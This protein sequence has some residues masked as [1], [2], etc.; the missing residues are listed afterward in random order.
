MRLFLRNGIWW[1][2]FSD[3]DGKRCRRTTRCRDEVAAHA[4]MASM[5]TQADRI[6]AGL[7][8]PPLP[9]MK[10][11]D[12]V[13]SWDNALA[14]NGRD[15]AYRKRARR[16][17]ERLGLEA[18]FGVVSAANAAAIDRWLLDIRASRMPSTAN[19]ARAACLSFLGHCVRHGWIDSVPIRTRAFENKAPKRRRALL[20]DEL[21]R[22]LGCEDIPPGRRRV[23]GILAY[24]GLRAG[25]LARLTWSNVDGNTI[26]IPASIAKSGRDEVLPLSDRATRILAS[27]SGGVLLVS[28]GAV[29][30]RCFQRDLQRAGIQ[31]VDARGRVAVLHSLRH[32]FRSM[33]ARAGASDAQARALMRHADPSVTG[34][35]QDDAL[36]DLRQVVDRLSA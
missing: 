3:H 21:E 8:P 28:G 22:L 5:V 31:A 16:Y 9:A 14:A 11:A 17:V 34:G 29:R 32:T 12:A 2:D 10:Y 23:Y 1:A 27:E 35:Y 4:V 33:L 24:T 19:N 7:I 20:L 15:E 30:G 25:E 18:G 26:N 13:D 6:R 36:L